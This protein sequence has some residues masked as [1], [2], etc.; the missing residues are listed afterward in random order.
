MKTKPSRGRVAEVKPQLD[1]Y[2]FAS[3][4]DKNGIPDKEKLPNLGFSYEKYGFSVPT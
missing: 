3:G 1:E 2:Y 4:W